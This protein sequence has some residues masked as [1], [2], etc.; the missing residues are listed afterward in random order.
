MERI[1]IILLLLVIVIVG[2]RHAGTKQG[3]FTMPDEWRVP[4]SVA[5]QLKQEIENGGVEHFS[6]NETA[7]RFAKSETNAHQFELQSQENGKWITNLMLQMPAGV[8]Y[9]TEDFDHDKYFDLS[10]TLEPNVRI[11]FFDASLK[12]FLPGSVEFPTDYALLDSNRLIYGAN[13]HSAALW[14]V[15]IFSI[16]NRTKTFFYQAKLFW[17]D[18]PQTGRDELRNAILYKNT[19]G[20][21]LADTAFVSNKLIGKDFG[22][23][24][25]RNYMKQIVAENIR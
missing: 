2:C 1:K 11:Y 17:E 7:F 25:L 14:N 13:Q 3:L 6:I 5:K 15:E 19:S 21:S 16:A 20:N 10:L 22:E 4:D 9:L 12:R 18:N 24:S 23:F 8:F